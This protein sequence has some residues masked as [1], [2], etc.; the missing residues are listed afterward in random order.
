MSDICSDYWYIVYI[1]LL[2]KQT[3][4][5]DKRWEK[6]SVYQISDFFNKKKREEIK[7]EKSTAYILSSFPLAASSTWTSQ[8]CIAVEII[9]TIHDWSVKNSYLLGFQRRRFVRVRMTCG[10]VWQLA[11]K[12]ELEK[13]NNNNKNKI[14]WHMTLYILCWQLSQLTDHLTAFD[15]SLTVVSGQ[16]ANRNQIYS[17]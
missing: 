9:W 2:S 6:R 17:R 15:S 7:H 16:V 11:H 3:R 13:Y 4:E 14:V 5:K 10:R 1:C 8:H 12:V